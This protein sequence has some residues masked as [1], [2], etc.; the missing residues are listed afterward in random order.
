MGNDDSDADVGTS[1]HD[2]C[3]QNNGGR[4]GGFE[5]GKDLFSIVRELCDLILL[6]NFRSTTV[7]LPVHKDSC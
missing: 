1:F 2:E 7:V 6:M 3:K 4:S 5:L